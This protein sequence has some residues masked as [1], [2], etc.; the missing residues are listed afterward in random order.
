MAKSKIIK[1]SGNGS[2][3][4]QYGTFFTFEYEFEDG[5]IGLANHQ[6]DTPKYKEGDFVEYEISGQDK[7]GNKKIKFLD[8]NNNFQKKGSGNNKSFA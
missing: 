6:T 2:W 1:V 8:Q 5:T 7:M 4:G 3:T